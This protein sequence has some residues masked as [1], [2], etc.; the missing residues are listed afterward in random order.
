MV[1]LVF[2]VVA[3]IDLLQDCAAAPT[4]RKKH[5]SSKQ[6]GRALKLRFI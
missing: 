3:T 6:A 1:K 5:V 2:G 4:G